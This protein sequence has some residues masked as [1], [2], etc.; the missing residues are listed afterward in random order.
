MR[1]CLRTYRAYYGRTQGAMTSTGDLQKSRLM[2][3]FFVSGRGLTY[4]QATKRL[5]LTLLPLPQQPPLRE[6]LLQL[7]PQLE[8]LL[9]PLALQEQRVQASLL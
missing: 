8:P 3:G 6:P 7:L 2:A 5:D 1:H 9:Q 4:R